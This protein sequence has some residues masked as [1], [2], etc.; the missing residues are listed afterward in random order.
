MP[1]LLWQDLACRNFQCDF[2]PVASV[3]FSLHAYNCIQCNQ[4]GFVTWSTSVLT[5]F[6]NVILQNMYVRIQASFLCI[7]KLAVNV[8]NIHKSPALLFLIS[9]ISP[10]SSSHPS[11]KMSNWSRLF[12][13]LKV[14]FWRYCNLHTFTQKGL[15]W[16]INIYCGIIWRVHATPF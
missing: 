16:G 15:F 14:L 5:H 9:G 11:Q 3:I 7:C 13:C 8:Q 10:L 2:T 1:F 6:T 12:L 4:F